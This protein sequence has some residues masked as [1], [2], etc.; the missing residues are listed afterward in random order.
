M[1]SGDVAA[2]CCMSMELQGIVGRRCFLL[3]LYYYVRSIHQGEGMDN[4]SSSSNGCLC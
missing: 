3:K 2:Y 4:S 1:R